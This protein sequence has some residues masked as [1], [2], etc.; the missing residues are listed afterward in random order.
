MHRFAQAEALCSAASYLVDLLFGFAGVKRVANGELYPPSQTAAQAQG[1]PA[2]VARLQQSNVGQ[3]EALALLSNEWA[4]AQKR[5]HLDKVL[6]PQLF[7]S[8]QQ[9]VQQAGEPP[10]FGDFDSLV[11]GQYWWQRLQ[12]VQPGE[13][14]DLAEQRRKQ[15]EEEQL[16]R[17]ELQ[18]QEA[19]HAGLHHNERSMLESLMGL[20]AYKS[21]LEEGARQLELKDLQKVQGHPQQLLAS[22]SIGEGAYRE[23]LHRAS[24]LQANTQ[25]LQQY[26]ATSDSDR[27]FRALAADSNEEPANDVFEAQVRKAFEQEAEGKDSTPVATDD[28][29]DRGVVGY[30]DFT[31][32][33]PGG[34]YL[35]EVYVPGY[36]DEAASSSLEDE[37]AEG[38][39]DILDISVAHAG[40]TTALRL[41]IETTVSQ[42]DLLQAVVSLEQLVE[43]SAGP[44]A[45]VELL[46][47]V[48][49]Q[50]SARDMQQQQQVHVTFDMGDSSTASVWIDGEDVTLAL[51]QAQQQGD[52][53]S[54]T[55]NLEI[56]TYRRDSTLLLAVLVAVPITLITLGI[57]TLSE[58]LPAFL[59]DLLA[60][61]RHLRPD[62]S[63]SHSD[64]AADTPQPCIV[65]HVAGGPAMCCATAQ[66]PRTMV[67]GC[68]TL[69]EPLM[70]LS[71]CEL[72][73]AATEAS[74][75]QRGYGYMPPS[76]LKCDAG[77][78]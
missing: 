67:K 76:Q 48:S 1:E 73:D 75:L 30:Y 41:T 71:D 8:A 55:V 46:S 39:M 34:G 13:E 29:P 51:D 68:S 77:K 14:G 74:S 23:S 44:N 15:Q 2:G 5:Q 59:P 16:L 72:E 3:D 17:Q 49:V 69:E 9:P 52:E 33:M 12:S 70:D 26:M 21:K 53:V 54:A 35:Q 18:Q 25:V 78:V 65:C 11:P 31:Y 10:Q 62:H 19:G 57:M 45:R 47:A 50:S 24:L 63:P 66:V 37:V 64:Q 61:C 4:A 42:N 38:W 32:D 7:S 6:A 56:V 58:A 27:Y 28:H 40:G 60:L 43:G 36:E 22:S 20:L